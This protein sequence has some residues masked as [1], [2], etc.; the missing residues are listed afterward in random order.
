MAEVP[1][2]QAAGIVIS[3]NADRE[4]IHAEISKVVHRI[5]AAARN[6]G[7][8]AVAQDEHGSL[9]GDAR[10]LAENKF[11]GDH[12]AKHGDGEARKGLDYF[13]QVLSFLGR[14]HVSEFQKIFSRPRFAFRNYAQKSIQGGIGL[15]QFHG[16][17]HHRDFAESGQQ[18]AEV[19][20]V[21]LGSDE[22]PGA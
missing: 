6:D 21:F 10:D 19:D 18:G 14:L 17:A 20:R 3:K 9:A 2:Q 12:I 11:V 13:A 16:D 5:R 1:Q 7:T 8:L 15:I 22:S 4:N